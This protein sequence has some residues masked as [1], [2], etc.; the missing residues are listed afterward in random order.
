MNPCNVVYVIV[1]KLYESPM[2]AKLHVIPAAQKLFIS[3]MIG[4]Y[5]EPW[6]SINSNVSQAFDMIFQIAATVVPA[7][8]PCV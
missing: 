3:T 1:T 7:R 8:D 4:G 2:I 5:F 6:P